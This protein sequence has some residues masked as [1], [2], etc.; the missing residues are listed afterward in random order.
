MNMSVDNF[1]DGQVEQPKVDNKAVDN[2]LDGKVEK[3]EE[4]IKPRIE[5][6]EKWYQAPMEVGAGFNDKLLNTL[7]LPNDLFN[8]SAEKL[9]IDVKIP[10]TRQLGS[11]LRIGY[12]EGEEPDTGS[13]TAGKV[14]HRT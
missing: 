1:L 10:S 6:S 14:S 9:G 2:F 7:D 4:A 5:E 8:W 13:Y 11:D 12:P 3:K